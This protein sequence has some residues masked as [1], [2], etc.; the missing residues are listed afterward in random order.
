[1]FKALKQAEYPDEIT[2]RRVLKQIFISSSL[3][4]T[5]W[6]IL[7][8]L[9]YLYLLL[10]RKDSCEGRV[11]RCN[12]MYEHRLWLLD[13]YYV[14]GE[15]RRNYCPIAYDACI[16]IRLYMMHCGPVLDVSQLTNM[17][18]DVVSMMAG[19][20]VLHSANSRINRHSSIFRVFR[21]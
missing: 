10:L 15:L 13:W 8:M 12:I 17:H 21:V 3:H 1:M 11:E 19:A 20:S 18:N 2:D 14:T 5:Y 6:R 16:S 4:F 9:T 7:S